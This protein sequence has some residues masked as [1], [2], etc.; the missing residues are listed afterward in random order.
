MCPLCRKILQIIHSNLSLDPVL[1]SRLS[2]SPPSLSVSTPKNTSTLL[3]P[4][5]TV[6]AAPVVSSGSARLQLRR[7][8]VARRRTRSKR[9]AHHLSRMFSISCGLHPCMATYAMCM[10]FAD[11]D[12][13]CLVCVNI[14]ALSCYVAV[15]VSQVESIGVY[16][17]A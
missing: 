8:T 15:L 12:C 7:R 2:T 11:S 4:R 14:V 5:H 10:R 3:S 16:R 6:E 9:R 13:I 1:A 17:D